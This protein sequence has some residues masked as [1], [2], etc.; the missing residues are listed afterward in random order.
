MLDLVAP[1][2]GRVAFYDLSRKQESFEEALLKGLSQNPKRIPSHFLYDAQGSALFDRICQLTEYYP[3]RTEMKILADHADDIA[4]QIGPEA[5]LIELGSGS[6]VKVRRLLDAMD[7]PRA[8]IPI[9]VSGEHLLAAAE[10]LA[11]AYPALAVA[12]ICADYGDTFPLPETPGAGRQVAFFP[13]STIGNLEPSDAEPFLAGW[14]RSGVDMIV[15]VDLI[16]AR[17]ILEPA[18]DDAEGVTS[19]FSLNLLA[20]A[21][22]EAGANFDLAAFAHRSHWDEAQRRITIG[23]ESLKGQ[24]VDAAGQAFH[25]KAGERI[26]TEHSYKYSVEGF[27]ALA[28]RAGYD[29]HAVWTDPG[30]L[31]S[32]HDLKAGPA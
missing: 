6:S 7:Q 16:K 11:D 27:Q 12:A 8:Y 31:F 17:E 15:G 25:F 10:A 14:A 20:R 24:S 1:V 30:D 19:A 2:R 22:R 3:T 29:P 26:E 9:D 13:G 21:N 23:I 32:V 18:Y 4:R 5:T 28:R